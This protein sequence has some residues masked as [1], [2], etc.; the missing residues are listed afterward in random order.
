[1]VKGMGSLNSPPI[2]VSEIQ[3]F[4]ATSAHELPVSMSVA[5]YNPSGT[6]CV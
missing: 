6:V 2:K 4:D 5:I 3:V 1:M